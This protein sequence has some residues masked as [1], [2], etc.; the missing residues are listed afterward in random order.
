MKT[1]KLYSI[2][3]V[4]CL[5]IISGCT[6]KNKDKLELRIFAAASLGEV[7]KALSDS[8]QTKFEC[9]VKTNIAS[10]GTLAQQ[11][12]Q[13]A[14]A[15]I[16][17]S[18]NELWI[19]Y[20]DSLG[21]LKQAKKVD[22]AENKLVLI[23]HKS[24]K[25]DPVSIDS[26]FNIKTLIGKGRIAIGN[27]KHVPVGQYAQ[28]TINHFRWRKVIEENIITAN[29]ARS[30]LMLVEMGEIPFGIVYRSD[31]LHSDKVK[32]IGTFPSH[33]HE[34]IVYIASSLNKNKASKAFIEFI[35]SETAKSIYVE[36]G[37]KP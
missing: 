4:A 8:F 5:F 11:I 28:Q 24:L 31:A 7:T 19:N 29:N 14:N 25:I 13:G 37:L 30:T 33:S 18:A 6:P 32:L 10:S 21:Y 36:Q 20:L 9:T 15:D 1:T 35:Q 27:P 23:C 16:F 2:I 12:S 17:L 26:A 22:F 3:L 34:N